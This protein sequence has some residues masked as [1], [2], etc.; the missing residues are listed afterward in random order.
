[1]R[2]I[3]L[4]VLDFA[5]KMA[6]GRSRNGG[7]LAIAV[8]QI[9]EELPEY[10]EQLPAALNGLFWGVALPIATGLSILAVVG[11]LLYRILYPPS[12]ES[13]HKAAILVLQRSSSVLKNPTRMQRRRNEALIRAA[14]KLLRKAS[15]MRTRSTATRTKQV[16]PSVASDSE[17]N[18]KPYYAPAILSLAALYVYRLGDGNSAVQLLESTLLSP[19]MSCHI[20]KNDLQDARSILLDARAVLAGQG[21]MIQHELRETE[22]LALSYCEASATSAKNLGITSSGGAVKKEQ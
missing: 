13:L 15:Q 6:H 9:V 22:Y 21:Q 16:S 2:I 8:H 3:F 4:A 5:Q 19:I 14:V 11:M 1:M 10:L 12:P 20:S 7:G 17:Y 18:H